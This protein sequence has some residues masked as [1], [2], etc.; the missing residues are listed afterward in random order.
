M[1]LRTLLTEHLLDVHPHL[2]AARPRGRA[3]SG[4]RARAWAPDLSPTQAPAL[5]VPVL[6]VLAG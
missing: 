6:R 1:I 2:H 3:R 5:A 4:P